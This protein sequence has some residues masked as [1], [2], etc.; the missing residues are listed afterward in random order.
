MSWKPCR[1]NSES[2]GDS[3]QPRNSIDPP[4]PAGRRRQNLA[5]AHT[6]PGPNS[7][8]IAAALPPAPCNAISVGCGAGT[9]GSARI[10]LRWRPPTAIHS[11]VTGPAAGSTRGGGTFCRAGSCGPTL[12][13]G[14]G[15]GSALCAGICA[16][17]ANAARQKSG[18]RRRILLVAASV[19]IGQLVVRLQKNAVADAL[20]AV[21]FR[22]PLQHP[23][24]LDAP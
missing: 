1:G 6:A 23:V 20:L 12:T 10:W 5:A 16:A 17:A 2:G 24:L 8:A 9:F 7:M 18:V 3:P 22:I 21:H 13:G 11:V 14:S 4:A 19:E 15:S